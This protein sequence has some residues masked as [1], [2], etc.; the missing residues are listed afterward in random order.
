MGTAL[1]FVIFY[2]EFFLFTQTKNVDMVK[3]DIVIT[4]CLMASKLSL[5][6]R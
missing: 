3:N 4:S 2:R 6:I 1:S 5:T